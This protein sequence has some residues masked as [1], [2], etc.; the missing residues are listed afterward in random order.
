MEIGKKLKDLRLQKNLTQEEL[1]ER[2]DLT[3]GYISQLENNLS[4]PSMETFFD[5]LEVLGTTP[6]DFFDSEKESQSVVY[7][8]ND[9]TIFEDEEKGYAMTWLISDSND[10]EMEPV[11][12]TLKED[13]EFKQFPPSLAET[14]GYVLAGTVGLEIGEQKFQIK[15]G[16]SFYYEATESHRMR[17]ASTKTTKVLLV[18]TDSYL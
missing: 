2:T 13:G 12:I 15:K 10:K 8:K 4:S 11:M 16:Q 14:F 9:V 7:T 3:K 17:N 5:V 6:K 1:G 18:V